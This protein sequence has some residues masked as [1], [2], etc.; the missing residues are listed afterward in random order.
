MVNRDGMNQV[1]LA[2]ELGI[3]PAAINYWRRHGLVAPIEERGPGLPLEFSDEMVA[4]A[5]GVKVLTSQGRTIEEVK[6]IMGASGGGMRGL[7]FSF[8][9]RFGAAFEGRK[10][11]AEILRV[12]SWV[13]RGKPLDVSLSD[14]ETMVT[15]YRQYPRDVPLDYEHGSAQAD[16]AGGTAIAAGWLKDLA[17][18]DGALVG[19]FDL[20]D[21]AAEWVRSGEYLL[22]SA[23]FHSDYLHPEA[24]QYIG[25]TLLAVAL[26]NRPFV[27][28]L[29]PV[30]M[31]SRRAETENANL[32]VERDALKAENENLA[33][34][35]LMAE[36]E[37]SNRTMDSILASYD[38]AKRQGV[39]FGEYLLA[40]P[41]G[42]SGG[43]SGASAEDRTYAEQIGDAYE[44]DVAAA[45]KAGRPAPQV[46]PWSEADKIENPRRWEQRDL[47]I[48]K[49]TPEYERAARI[50]RARL[51]SGTATADD[52]NS[53]FRGVDAAVAFKEID[54]KAKTL[55]ARDRNL[56]LSAAHAKVMDADPD[57][58][59]RYRR[60]SLGLPEVK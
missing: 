34:K 48:R 7:E 18:E 1:E 27:T 55:M 9:G 46:G 60:A 58:S 10:A 30:T 38:E 54:S 31:L 37:R 26:T 20:T 2:R 43:G 35:V 22:L 12:G 23:E 6:R 29:A 57:L 39:T 11:R 28:G 50:R 41:K 4:R 19:T 15:N 24:Q 36:A 45:V 25:P 49:G 40:N 47:E 42:K 53:Q 3:T 44:A 17:V 8:T 51:E 21:R 5:A 33:L 52:M 32:K 13:Y 14:L 56:T 59:D 16:G